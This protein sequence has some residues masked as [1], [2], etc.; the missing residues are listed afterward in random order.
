MASR[1]RVLSSSYQVQVSE[2]V[3]GLV[4]FSDNEEL[5]QV[6]MMTTCQ[7]WLIKVS[8]ILIQLDIIE[9]W[10][11]GSVQYAHMGALN[12]FTSQRGSICLKESQGDD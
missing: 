6:S 8:R 9:E 12:K 7:E 3:S 10:D 4:Q 2:W 11:C 5:A 1:G